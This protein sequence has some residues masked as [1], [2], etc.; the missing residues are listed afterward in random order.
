MRAVR[1]VGRSLDAMA[2]AADEFGSIQVSP[3]LLTSPDAGFH[4]DLSRTAKT[5][6]EEAKSEVT[7]GSA[8]LE[9]VVQGL[10]AG[11]AAQADIT[12]VMGGAQQISEFLATTTRRDRK[13]SLLDEAVEQ[14]FQA[15]LARAQKLTNETERLDAI[16]RAQKARADAF[17]APENLPAFPSANEESIPGKASGVAKQPTEARAVLADPKFKDFQKLFQE[18]APLPTLNNRAA[19]NKAAGDVAT[20][21]IFRLLGN[22]AQAQAFTGRRVAFGVVEVT[23][24]PGWR[25]QSGY[26]AEVSVLTDYEYGSARTQVLTRVLKDPAIPLPVRVKLADDA[27]LVQPD[28]GTPTPSTEDLRRAR[29][30]DAAA[31]QRMIPAQ[32]QWTPSD[33]QG[34]HK[35]IVFAISPFSDIEVSDQASSLRRRDEFAL[36]LGLVLRYF[37]AQAEAEVIEQHVRDRQR[38]ARSR[39]VSAAVSTFS[40]G[41]MVGFQI[42]PRYQ[43]IGDPTANRQKAANVLGRQSFPSLLLFGFNPEDIFPKIAGADTGTWELLEP[44]LAMTQVP[45]WRRMDRPGFFL[46]DPRFDEVRKLEL[47]VRHNQAKIATECA[48]ITLGLKPTIQA[49]ESALKYQIF[50]S[51]SKLVILSPEELVPLPQGAPEEPPVVLASVPTRIAIH[52]VGEV[53]SVA[54]IGRALDQISTDKIREMDGNADV[55]VKHASAD[56][57]H[58][59]LTIRNA[60]PLVFSLPVK[61]GST[62]PPGMELYSRPLVVSEA[63]PR[64]QPLRPVLRARSNSSDPARTRERTVEISPEVT[65]KELQAA[66]EALEILK[67]HE[68]DPK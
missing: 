19:L 49:R 51:Q 57:L 38:D 26:A 8:A 32:M 64:P 59:E 27:Y 29:A 41:T 33:N 55:V 10:S 52:K 2:V 48:L 40:Q 21:A 15:D 44:Q 60:V 14:Q 35:P 58:L 45:A 37:G 3:P 12:Q 66:Q 62:W 1:E 30:L 56:A 63:N 4:F 6:F 11:L 43:A 67:T 68:P 50:G 54:I 17:S 61:L 18:G 65:E 28:F 23:V 9:Q 22:P 46:P 5:Y 7:S 16:A 53:H 34:A 20:E 36:N 42:G 47:S 24:N 13:R 39:T 25:T 31:L